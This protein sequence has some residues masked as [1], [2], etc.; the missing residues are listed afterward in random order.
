MDE[1][2]ITQVLDGSET[3]QITKA[4]QN[5]LEFGVF[6]TWKIIE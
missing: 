4:G 2:N 6:N 3:M 5:N 1:T